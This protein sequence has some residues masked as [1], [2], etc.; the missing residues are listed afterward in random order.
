MKL[1]YAVSIFFAICL[2]GFLPFVVI[3][4]NYNFH[5]LGDEDFEE[6]WGAPYEG[7]K[8]E[9]RWSL[10][11]PFTYVIRRGVF[12]FFAVLMPSFLAG[13]LAIQFYLTVGTMIYLVQCE[14][15]EDKLLGKLEL[16]N[17]IVAVF[18][19]DVLFNL[20]PNYQTLYVMNMLGWAFVFCIFLNLFI[21]LFFIVRG[22]CADIRKTCKNK[23]YLK[24]YKVWYD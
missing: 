1:N 22:G 19:I 15:F 14:P 2:I 10:I 4:Y 11:F 17:E 23:N 9:S 20:A 5:R 24:R 8:K 16:M 18:T 21:H 6:K 13:Q 3:F 7:L 12:A